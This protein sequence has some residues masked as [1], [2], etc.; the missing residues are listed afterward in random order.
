MGFLKVVCGGQQV[1][2]EVVT[3]LEP[4]SPSPL[5]DTPNIGVATEG[6]KSGVP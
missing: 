5:E 3:S 1:D 6:A 2:E 4:K